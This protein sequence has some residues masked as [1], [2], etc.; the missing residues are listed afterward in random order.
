MSNTTFK[1]TNVSSS[2]TITGMTI[3]NAGSGYTVGSSLTMRIHQ[4]TTALQIN[5]DFGE[6]IFS[7]SMQGEV[8]W[9]LNKPNEGATRLVNS[10]Q[11]CIDISAAGKLA[12]SRSYL[13]G[14]E[15]CLRLA[16]IMTQEQL[17]AALE[18][19]IEHREG[20]LTWQALN[21]SLENLNDS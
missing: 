3:T 10:L 11:N 15:K 21:N 8:K 13:R 4:P 1:V 14:I 9:H 7:V 12:L 19:E 2:G 18:T 16:R 6:T 20:K 5:N 17:I